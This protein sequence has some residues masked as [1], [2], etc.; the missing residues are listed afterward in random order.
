MEDIR[1]KLRIAGKS[2]GIKF[3]LAQLDKFQGYAELLL[4]WNE[5][6]NLTAITEPD[7]IVMKHF[8]DSLSVLKAFDIKEKAKMIDVGTGAGFPGLPIK[9]MRPDIKLTLLD[10]S[11]KRLQFL[12]AVSKELDFEAECI[13]KRAEEAG[14]LSDMRESYDIAVS[15][16][17]AP[18][19]ILSEYCIPLI[20]MK[21]IFAAMKGPGI[22][23]ELADAQN[24]IAKLGGELD[25]IKELALPSG[26][27]RN[28]IVVRKYDFMPKEYPRHGGTIMK[29][30]IK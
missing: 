28:I 24:A 8:V 15:R 9:I 17:V 13:H 26:E 3:D 25:S 14:R 29:H 11:N 5:R 16:A 20:K 6:F 7:E 19:N 2:L 4:E 30:P 23:E 27:A 18:L 1:E 21:G 22:K 10:G 12:A